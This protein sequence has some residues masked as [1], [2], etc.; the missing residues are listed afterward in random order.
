MKMRPQQLPQL[1][2]GLLILPKSHVLPLQ[3]KQ[4]HSIHLTM[5]LFDCND[6]D[7]DDVSMGLYHEKLAGE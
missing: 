3:Q 1:L 4:L 6:G 2:L 7:D 5:I